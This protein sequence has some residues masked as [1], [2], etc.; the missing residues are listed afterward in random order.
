MLYAFYARKKWH[1]LIADWKE[2]IASGIPPLTLTKCKRDN[3]IDYKIYGNSVQNGEPTPEAPVEIESVGEKTN[4]LFNKNTISLNKKLY[5]GREE[6]DE[7]KYVSD[8]I[9]CRNISSVSINLAGSFGWYDENKNVVSSEN[10]SAIIFRNYSKP[11]G[12]V[13]LRLD[14]D[15]TVITPD[16]VMCVSGKYTQNT[17]PPH[18]PYG[19]KIPVKVSND[20]EEFITNIYL[21]EPLRKI[22]DFSD[23]IDFKN[24]KVIRKI[25]KK[26]CTGTEPISFGA[27]SI[28]IQGLSPASISGNSTNNV[29]MCNYYKSSD[30][31]S[32]WRKGYETSYTDTRGVAAS[33]TTIRIVDMLNYPN[34]N[35]DPTQI[36]LFKEWLAG[37]YANGTPMIIDYVLDKSIEETIELPNIPTLKGTTIIEIDDNVNSSYMEAVYKGKGKLQLLDTENNNILNSILDTDTDTDLNITNTEIAEILDEIIGG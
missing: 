24:K 21:D 29:C 12:A 25:Y 10:K 31:E 8:Y 30:W 34:A 7:N 9:D 15:K 6:D 13:Y 37:L 26:V 33:T 19:Y 16:E 27:R 5:V 17:M 36:S 32:L 3:L 18:E 35:T 20:K 14:F 4:N 23:Y 11:D 1:N 22:G 28:A 2:L